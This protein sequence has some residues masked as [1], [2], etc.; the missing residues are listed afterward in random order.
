MEHLAIDL[1]GRESQICVRSSDGQIVEDRRCRTAALSAYLA[2]LYGAENRSGRNGILV[3]HAAK[4]VPTPNALPIGRG[5]RRRCFPRRLRRIECQRSVWTMDI[6]MSDERGNSPLKMSLIEDQQPVETLGASRPHK[7]LCD[8]IRLRRS[9]RRPDDLH[10]D[11]PKH[12]IEAVGELLVPIA[13]HE[14]ERL[15]TVG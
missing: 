9:K 1:G 13:N 10:A 6:V 3:N 11:T 8:A 4:A 5:C 12:V 14:A 2:I 7:P 15:C